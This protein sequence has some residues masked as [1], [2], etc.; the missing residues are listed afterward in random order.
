MAGTC[1][2]EV[3]NPTVVFGR[4]LRW[5]SAPLAAAL[6][7][8]ACGGDE[9]EQSGDDSPA[10]TEQPP[11][12]PTTQE[13]PGTASP[14]AEPGPVEPTDVSEITTGLD[15]PWALTFRDDGSALVSQRDEG[16]IISV[17]PDGEVSELGE[18]EGVTPDFEGGLLGITLHPEDDSRLYIY[19]TTAEDNRV[20]VADVSGGDLGETTTL[21]EGIPRQSQHNGGRLRFGPDGMLYVSTGDAGEGDRSQDPE[22]LAGKIL[23]L[24]PDGDVPEDNP[25]PESPV[26]SMGHRNVQGLAFD[27]DG[28]LWSSE[29][30]ADAW[31]ELNLI[32][33][34]GNYGWPEVEGEGGE[35]EYIDP[36]HVWEPA[37]ASPSGIAYVQDTL[38]MTSLR[39]QRL[40]TIPLSEG[41]PGEP[42]EHFT[43]EYGRL[44][45][46]VPA[47]DGSLWM[48]T[49]NTDG[50]D[51][52]R[53]GDDRILRLEL[54]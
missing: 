24:T 50:R 52:P 15:V 13:T 36:L 20:V 19:L 30:G 35:P 10:A 11:A 12:D 17:T 40:W 9:P 37:E 46:V 41:Q 7:L 8:S 42:Q 43:E 29:F 1:D 38:F 39:G 26:Y 27:D 53:E 16:T 31:D 4:R 25:D 6:L 22:S 49:N 32:E 48:L 5:A 21:I 34:E 23:R 3:M 14:T 54:G 47:P 33:P 2:D 28:R 51:E 45:D 18:V 44:R